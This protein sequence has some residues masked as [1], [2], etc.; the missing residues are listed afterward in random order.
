M[1]SSMI[2]YFKYVNTNRYLN[3]RTH[4]HQRFQNKYKITIKRLHIQRCTDGFLPRE[5]KDFL[6]V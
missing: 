4:T 5:K 1:Q 6:T 2:Y 3:L